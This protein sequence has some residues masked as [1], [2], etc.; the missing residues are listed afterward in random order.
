M[1]YH[2]FEDLRQASA[3]LYIKII[4]IAY[5]KKI[6]NMIDKLDYF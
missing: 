3:H 4:I 1:I 5:R 2:S 6:Y